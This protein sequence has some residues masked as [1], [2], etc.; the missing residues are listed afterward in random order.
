MEIL[1]E[2]IET[3]Q[4]L[5]IVYLKSSDQKSTRIITPKKVGTMQFQGKYFEGLEAFCH[6]VQETRVFSVKKI[7]EVRNV[8]AER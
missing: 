3:Q 5:E 2:A 1:V 8:R 6:R 7:L 4:D